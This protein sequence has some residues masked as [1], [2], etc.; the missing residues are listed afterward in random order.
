MGFSHKQKNVLLIS[1]LSYGNTAQQRKNLRHLPKAANSVEI[2]P[3][4][5]AKTN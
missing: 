4:I 5:S 1:I 2:S 3:I